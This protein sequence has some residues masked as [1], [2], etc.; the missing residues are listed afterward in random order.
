MTSAPPLFPPRPIRGV[1]VLHRRQNCA[2]QFA[3]LEVDFEPAAGGFAFEVPEGLPSAGDPPDDLS[4]LVAAA[5][6]GI[7]EELSAS[8]HGLVVSVRVVL[9]SIRTDTFG[10]HELAFRVAGGLAAR[11]ALARGRGAGD[12]QGA[13]DAR[14]RRGH[15]PTR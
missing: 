7:Q 3:E 10:S 15:G 14:S 5:A 6:A 9:R 12:G 1:R 2:P 4:R 8:G 11:E 13:P